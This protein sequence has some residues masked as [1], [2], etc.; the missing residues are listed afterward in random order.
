MRAICCLIA[1]WLGFVGTA[2]AAE[3]NCKYIRL[4]VPYAAGG[5]TDVAARLV[6]KGLEEALNKSI[7]VETR[8]GASGNIGTLAVI[9]S[10]P[11]G[12]T[13][14]INGAMIATFPYSFSKLDYDPLKD[15]VA[16]GGVGISPTVLVTSRN[17]ITDLKSLLAKAKENSDG[18]SYASAGYGL[19]QHLAIEELASRTGS[20]LGHIPYRGGGQATTDM[21]TGR[22]DFGSVA[23]GS[24]IPMIKEGKLKAIA[25]VQDKRTSLA[26][27]T[28]TTA[29]QG[30]PGLNAGVH[31]MIFAP[32]KTPKDVVA[33]LSNA[34]RSVVSDPK[35]EGRFA[36]IGFEPTPISS[37]EA[38]QI[39][40]KTG[41]DWASI[42]KRLGIKLD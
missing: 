5:A 36:D 38:Q 29:E 11:D 7:V 23:T 17:D 19:L 30:Q 32:A 13:L 40:H 14:L 18:L 26:P 37:D 24:V 20:K 35:L 33:T 6:A 42:I 10:D 39:V 21:V 27:N 31:F 8:A 25:V 34:L 22:I 4:I 28:P 16:V 2:G 3:L 1:A 41:E 9:S 12:C 15:L